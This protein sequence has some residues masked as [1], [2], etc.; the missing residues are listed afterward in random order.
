MIYLDKITKADAASDFFNIHN[1]PRKAITMGVGTILDAKEII[2]MAFGEGKAN[3]VKKAIEGPVT[4]QVS[5]S[6]L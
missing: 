3:I 6:Y 4:S 5:A 2:I 1:V